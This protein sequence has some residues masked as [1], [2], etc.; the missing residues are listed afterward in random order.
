LILID[1][2]AKVLSDGDIECALAAS[3]DLM[4]IVPFEAFPDHAISVLR[5]LVAADI[6]AYSEIDPVRV[7][8]RSVFS[9]TGVAGPAELEIFAKHAMENPL[10]AHYLSTGDGAA[11]T[12]SEFMDLSTF[13]DTTV[14][15][16]F[17][18]PMGINYQLVIT[19]PAEMPLLI[20]LVCTREASD[21]IARDRHLLDLLGAHFARAHRN[22]LL[23]S[24]LMESRE[25]LQTLLAREGR[26]TA[27][28][29]ADGTLDPLSDRAHRLPR[30]E[31]RLRRVRPQRRHPGGTD[32]GTGSRAGRGRRLRRDQHR[33]AASACRHL[34]R[35]LHRQCR[36]AF[37]AARAR[38]DERQPRPDHSSR[39]GPT[40]GRR[41]P[42]DRRGR[43]PRAVR[44]RDRRP[45]RVR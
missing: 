44:G 26:V 21:F 22:S 33:E 11:H 31:S 2:G 16:H 8:E 23:F 40:R 27:L 29:R 7:F 25:A 36:S 30:R 28:V 42:G 5:S 12:V 19:L 38:G 20:G 24:R 10:V 18:R 32:R 39:P 15:K 4:E 1:G 35:T 37:R 43:P 13:Q 45:E 9:P 6:Y 3:R 41:C 34:R 14:W 17:Y